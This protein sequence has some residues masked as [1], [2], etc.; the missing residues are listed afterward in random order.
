[1]QR[2]SR[3]TTAIYNFSILEKNATDNI[4]TQV[5]HPIVVG[6]RFVSE[7][8]KFI[9]IRGVIGKSIDLTIDYLQTS[10]SS[11]GLKIY[12]FSAD[13]KRFVYYGR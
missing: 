1:V 8:L 5:S 11:S 4:P 13:D 3:R 9:L 6:G 7:E 2:L 12:K 10:Q